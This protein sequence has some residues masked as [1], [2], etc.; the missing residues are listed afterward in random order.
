MSLYQSFYNIH[1]A[2][3]FISISI[4]VFVRGILYILTV[5]FFFFQFV[6]ESEDESDGSVIGTVPRGCRPLES[7]DSDNWTSSN[8][9][10]EKD[11]KQKLT[12]ISNPSSIS[13]NDC[14]SDSS[15]GESDKCP[16]CLL[17]FSSQQIG[18]PD[19]CDHIFCSDCLTEWSNHVNTCPVDRKE[20]AFVLV[21]NK[22]G[23]NVIKS[24]PV[25]PRRISLDDLVEEQ[26][27]I[28]QVNLNYFCV[29]RYSSFT[30]YFKCIFI[31]L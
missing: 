5:S 24:I 29:N 9:D 12:S 14:H 25:K 28:C 30:V 31:A 1:Y 3:S 27:T 2:Q 8:S 6:T 19:A 10:N 23:G 16:V 21:R 7:D 20:F 26:P 11:D 15:E 13:K 4:Y 18:T 22:I 17:K